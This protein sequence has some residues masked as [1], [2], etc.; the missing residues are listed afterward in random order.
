M[1]DPPGD[2]DG[3]ERTSA[4][5]C[6]KVALMQPYHDAAEPFSCFEL[7]GSNGLLESVPQFHLPVTELF[8]PRL[9]M[10]VN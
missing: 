9:A 7:P 1:I 6:R 4:R 2:I 5:K 3:I 10:D 8:F